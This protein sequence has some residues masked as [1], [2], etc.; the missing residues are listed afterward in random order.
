[1]EAPVNYFTDRTS[2][3]KEL[4][5]FL[6]GKI[7]TK[8]M[9]DIN[10]MFGMGKTQL[11]R[12]A[13]S[14]AK[15]THRT[16]AYYDFSRKADIQYVDVLKSIS[17]QSNKAS[18][19]LN[20][21][22]SFTDYNNNI[23]D[24]CNAFNKELAEEIR[25][26]RVL[27]FFDSTEKATP[28]TLE[29]LETKIFTKH[30]NHGNLL[31]TCSGE[32]PIH[33][34]TADIRKRRTSLTL[35]SF[36]PEEINEMIASLANVYSI[37]EID[38]DS[39]E[40]IQYLSDGNPGIIYDSLYFLSD[41]FSQKEIHAEP[42]KCND[43]VAYLHQKIV[44]EK[45]LQQIENVQ[46]ERVDNIKLIS[47]IAMLR[48]VDLQSFRKLVAINFPESF[49]KQNAFYYDSLLKK[50]YKQSSLFQPDYSSGYALNT[51]VRRISKLSKWLAQPKKFE[52]L[53]NEISNYY[54][55]MISKTAGIDQKS[56]IIEYLFTKYS[57]F[58]AC[59][60]LPE[61][62]CTLSANE[63][64]ELIDSNNVIQ[65]DSYVRDA[66]LIDIQNAIEA[67]EEL[68]DLLT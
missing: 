50:I 30:I 35:H 5:K 45:I 11:L 62:T 7:Y 20:L 42:K 9:M 49:A 59:I 8:T 15:K 13:Y 33:W 53:Q 52:W 12:W 58:P 14:G 29:L 43:L 48:K 27:F 68:K 60:G 51:C 25:S 64:T 23:D 36:T 44:H 40:L 47:N 37:N 38:D 4:C 56:A 10:G 65:E 16:V 61:R 39:I 66:H 31:I 26:N 1:M 3:R 24:L 18:I 67:D 32:K 55:F 17:E 2:E 57:T 22:N 28:K 41:E 54:K 63:I 21:A 34:K 19:V 46:I 6:Q